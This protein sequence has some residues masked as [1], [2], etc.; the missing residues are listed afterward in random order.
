MSGQG[1]AS[2]QP[3]RRLGLRQ[4]RW[5]WRRAR[6]SV[7]RPAD[8]EGRGALR[9]RFFGMKWLRGSSLKWAVVALGLLTTSCAGAI[10]AG[11]ALVVVGAG[12]LSM[13]CYDRMQVTV[14]DA[15]TGTKLCDAKVTFTEDGSVTE[16]TSCYTA[17]LSTGKYQLR[18]ER[19]GLVPYEAPVEINTGS[20]CRHAVQTVYVALDRP[21]RQQGPQL[22]APP[23]AAP[24]APLPAA[25]AAPPGTTTADPPP[26]APAPATPAS[27]APATP[28][29]PAPAAPAP[30]TSAFPDSR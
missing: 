7:W 15:L 14:T 30:A 29:P 9:A 1:G 2:R 24:A 25:P 5:Q 19:K 23:P 28:V 21:N 16:A 13:A 22:I 11:A 17:A 4:P 18:V 8:A 12:V 20:K 27:A 10:G 3:A 6:A 26:A